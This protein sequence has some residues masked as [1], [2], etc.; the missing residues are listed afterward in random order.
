MTYG[1][2]I[3]SCGKLALPSFTK[4]SQSFKQQLVL[5]RNF[6]SFNIGI[7]ARGSVDG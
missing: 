2:E 5:P 7:V 3:S 4:L 6:N 1:V